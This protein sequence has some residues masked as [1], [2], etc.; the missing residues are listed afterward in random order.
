M[1]RCWVKNNTQPNQSREMEFANQFYAIVVIGMVLL[2]GMSQAG[3]YYGGVRY[4]TL[5]KIW[6]LNVV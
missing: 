4:H 1:K 2:I 3:S 6:A 5:F